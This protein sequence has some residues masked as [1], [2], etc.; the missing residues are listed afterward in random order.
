MSCEHC[1]RAIEQELAQNPGV[2]KA[3]VT[4]GIVDLVFDEKSVTK[5]QLI[6]CIRA[7]GP[8]DVTG[9]SIDG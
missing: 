7:A 4:L 9:F 1:V 2:E 8:Y 3:R 5:S 6:E